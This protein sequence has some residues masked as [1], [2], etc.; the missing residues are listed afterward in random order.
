MGQEGF[1]RAV[2]F[3][4]LAVKTSCFATKLAA[5]SNLTEKS[6]TAISRV[7]KTWCKISIWP[8]PV[9]REAKRGLQNIQ[10]LAYYCYSLRRRPSKSPIY[11][12]ISSSLSAIM[13]KRPWDS[14]A[15][16][17]F[18]HSGFP[19]KTAHP[20][21]NFPAVFPPPTLYKVKTRGKF[22]IHA[23]NIVCGVRGE[24]GPV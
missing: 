4:S 11:W 24:V 3:Q 23:S 18:C 15:I 19:H 14:N 2:S 6:R 12:T 1:K 20:F 7:P 22:W 8:V 16:L 5:I 9:R 17:F 21:R 10:L 13:D